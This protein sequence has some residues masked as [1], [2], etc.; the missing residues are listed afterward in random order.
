MNHWKIIFIIV[1]GNLIEDVF[2]EEKFHT[3]NAV[4]NNNVNLD[5]DI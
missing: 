1:F 5:N 2:V 3:I 4:E